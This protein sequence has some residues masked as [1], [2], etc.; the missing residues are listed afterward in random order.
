MSPTAYVK[1][2][3]NTLGWQPPQTKRGG[4]TRYLGPARRVQERMDTNPALYTMDNLLLAVELLRREH[5]AYSPLGVF[6]HVER[7]LDV[8]FDRETDLD[9]DLREAIQIEAGR[10][11]PDGWVERLTRAMGPYRV[12]ALEE[13]KAVHGRG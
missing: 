7:A 3:E 8:A 11:D 5:K 4:Y 2:V 10:G 6:A 13:W 9:V 1:H 12:E